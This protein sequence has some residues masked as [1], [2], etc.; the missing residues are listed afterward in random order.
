MLEISLENKDFRLVWSTR[1]TV[2]LTDLPY[3]AYEYDGD[4]GVS[5]YVQQVADDYH[6]GLGERSSPLD[7]NGRRCTVSLK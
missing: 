1:E 4:G 5:H 2:F 6:Y 7:L 3:R